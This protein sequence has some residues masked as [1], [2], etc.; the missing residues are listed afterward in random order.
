MVSPSKG[1][2]S[3]RVNRP[4][5]ASGAPQ[6]VSEILFSWYVFVMLPL[7]STGNPSAPSLRLK[8]RMVL[9]NP[10]GLNGTLQNLCLHTH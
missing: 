2:L 5:R 7:N 6:A 10:C 4:A 1:G 8:G 3:S 9:I